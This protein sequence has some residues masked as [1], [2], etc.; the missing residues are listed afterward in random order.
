MESEDILLKKRLLELYERAESYGCAF[1]TDFLSL[2]EQS[3]LEELR[4]GSVLEGGYPLA[5][6]KIARFGESY[7]E[8]FPIVFVKIEP[9]QDK[10]ADKLSHRDFLGSILG[11][12]IKR[13]VLGDI[14]VRENRAHLV[15][16]DTIADFIISELNKVKHT[17]VRCVKED[18]LPESSCELPPVTSVVVPSERVD[19]IVAE[20]FNISRSESRRYFEKELVFINSRVVRKAEKT[21][22]P[23]DIVSVRGLGRFIY[24]GIDRTTA[25]GRLRV[26]VRR[27]T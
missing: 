16:L 8:D 2:A 10:F 15:C 25:K 3:I 26:S 19:A 12:G 4:L 24:V 27:F 20:V 6:R 21:P 5:E 17:N 22:E 9:L 14:I 1:Y 13:S 18:A 23:N 11:L 7:G